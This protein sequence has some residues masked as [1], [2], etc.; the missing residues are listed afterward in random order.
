MFTLKVLEINGGLPGGCCVLRVFVRYILK[1][2]YVP[3]K[4]LSEFSLVFA[5]AQILSELTEK[6]GNEGKNRN[7]GFKGQNQWHL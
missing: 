1:R 6:I 2:D 5:A 7:A 4:L 3:Q